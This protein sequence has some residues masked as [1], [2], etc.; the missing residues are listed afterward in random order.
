M[1]MAAQRKKG[2]GKVKNNELICLNIHIR[3]EG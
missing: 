3:K 1:T 2:K